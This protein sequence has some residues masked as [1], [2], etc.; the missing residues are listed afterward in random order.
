MR[1]R[2]MY[3]NG[4]GIHRE[5][6]FDLD[7]DAQATVFY[8]RNEAG[9]STIMGFVRSM[10]FGFPK[11]SHMSERFEPLSG[12][13][14]GGALT[15][16]DRMGTEIRLERY[17]KN[18]SLKLLFPD[19][20]E[21]GEAVLQSL[22]G[23]LTADLYRNLFA[24]S[25][26]ELQRIDTLH[27]EEISGFLFSTGMGISGGM[28]AQAE[29]KLAQQ[30]D[31]LYKR[32]GTKQ[33]IN[34]Q[35][36]MIEQ[37]VLELRR[38]KEKSGKYQDWQIELASLDEII[39]ADEIELSLQRAECD[40]LN[41][42]MQSRESWIQ[43]LEVES[44]LREIPE[45]VDFPEH[46]LSRFEKVQED[47]ERANMELLDVQQERAN[48]TEQLSGIMVNQKLIRHRAELEQLLEA[49]VVYSDS[50][51]RLADSLVEI[52][53]Y[54]MELHR[55][56]R[57]ISPDWTEQQLQQFPLSIHHREQVSA[58]AERFDS[59]YIRRQSRLIER[60]R[61]KEQAEQTRS[62][63]REQQYKLNEIMQ[64]MKSKF[65]Q[66]INVG[67]EQLHSYE[68]EVNK[69]WDYTKKQASDLIHVEERLADARRSEQ[70]LRA[71]RGSEHQRVLK[72]R[73]QNIMVRILAIAINI[74]VPLWIIIGLNSMMTGIS[75]LLLLGFLNMY[76]WLYK[77][78]P[79]AR[80]EMGESYYR[81]ALAHRERLEKEVQ[82]V[83][84]QWVERYEQLYSK[85][86]MY[87][88]IYA[89]QF[90]AAA[91]R[92][93][94]EGRE[95]T[96]ARDSVQQLE[97]WVESLQLH[98]SECKQADL[99]LRNA[100]NQLSVVAQDLDELN[101]RLT[102]MMDNE[103]K[104]QQDEAEL[105][106]EW[107]QWLE[108]YRL[109]VDVSVES[110]KTMFQ[111]AESGLQVFD[112]MTRMNNKLA[113]F[114]QVQRSFERTA[115]TFLH[116]QGIDIPLT[117]THIVYELKKLK[118]LLDGQV[119]I[120]ENRRQLEQRMNAL[121]SREQQCSGQVTSMM[122]KL[123][124]L[125]QAAKATDEDELR[126][127]VRL[128]DR[129]IEL[130]QKKRHLQIVI[131]TWVKEE[132]QY[133]LFQTLEQSDVAQIE[134]QLITVND[135][136]VQIELRLN[137]SKDRRGGLRKEMDNLQ[138]GG[139]HA[140]LL[141]RHQEHIAEFQQLASKW[142]ELALSAELMRRAKEIYERERQPAVLLRAS[143]YIRAITDGQ[144]VRVVS[145]L[146]E[147][148]I[149]V[150]RESGEQL[151]STFLSRGTAEQLYLAMRFA[152][153]DEYAKTVAL[154]LIMDDIFV[155]FDA[156]RLSRTLTVLSDVAQRHQIIVFTCHEHVLRALQSAL[157]RLQMIDLEG[158]R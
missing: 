143:Q 91:G 136:T 13:V 12:G 86:S 52:E 21:A 101:K 17:E 28:M 74:I 43:L 79:I 8:G 93:K 106:Q 56:L 57:L 35:L 33:M 118:E 153:A 148:S 39:T 127:W 6:I 125:L 131:F 150:E 67:R 85:L 152:L 63:L 140:E 59:N 112:L 116:D 60:E 55:Y 27:A 2:R 5:R 32:Q 132:H 18:G 104:Q 123:N 7:L 66:L 130:E 38:S 135:A 151:D 31:V 94:T 30:M 155:N 42:C 84:A 120:V 78:K 110:M 34:E 73:P 137:E 25:L 71:G 19:G 26:S 105:K 50:T 103:T 23:G 114:E 107:G 80:G 14:H 36:R 90:E 113:A 20:T 92:S 70:L 72:A 1:I 156:D 147:K 154:P 76:L 149:F 77:E 139:Q 124:E 11:R 68:A 119:N 46:V 133:K 75:I 65:H 64:E 58:Y 142:A 157:P 99:E 81:E 61:L 37:S 15:L 44:E 134:Q 141:Q 53:G 47:L 144:F 100:E 109:P 122:D 3:L 24:F 96:A 29:R 121:D 82:C 126:R 49:A 51:A 54:R 146:G 40:W 16:L 45:F 97:P 145:R 98:I 111:Y 108:H 87:P 117:V 48:A 10:L 83:R 4:F 95:Q 158:V 115:T 41:K 128:N 22:L 9:K 62:T 102:A 129:R 88:G 89:G 69:L 138:S